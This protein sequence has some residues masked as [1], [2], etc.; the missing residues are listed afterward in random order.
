MAVS[1]DRLI[2]LGLYKKA[3]DKNYTR[4]ISRAYY[5]TNKD[6]LREKRN[7]PSRASSATKERA[8]LKVAKNRLNLEAPYINKLLKA[9]GFPKEAITPEL[10]EVK[11]LII[12]TRRL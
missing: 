12:K 1:K 2:S 4:V 9:Q 10:I 3:Y 5:A 6:A 8:K 7:L 11:R